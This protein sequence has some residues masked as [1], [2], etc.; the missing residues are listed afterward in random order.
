L[1][2]QWHKQQAMRRTAAFVVQPQFV[3][4]FLLS[5]L[6]DRFPGLTLVCAETGTGWLTYLMHAADRRWET[7]R[8]WRDGA[9][10]PSEIVR[11]QVR[12]TFWYERAGNRMRDVIGVDNILWAS[13]YPHGTSSYPTS[14]E[15]IEQVLGDV[16]PAERRKLLCEN[17]L[18]VYGVP[19]E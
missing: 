6:A 8:R 19:A 14:R 18:R 16:D 11:R 1:P 2:A 10:R 12:V 15:L 4:N 17:V 9:R 7:E 5:G 3:G 13:D